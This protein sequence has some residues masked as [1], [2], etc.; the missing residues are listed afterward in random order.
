M[1]KTLLVITIALAALGFGCGH[2]RG[3]GDVAMT[4]HDE[5]HKT[6]KLS[7]GAHVEVAGINGSVKIETSDGDVAEVHILRDASDQQTLAKTAV[8]IVQSPNSLSVLGEQ[9]SGGGFLREIF[10]TKQHR[11]RLQVTLKIPKQVDLLAKGVN[12]P[13][14][15]GE[16]N[17]PVVVKS[18]NGPVE[19][20]QAASNS[21]VKGVNGPVSIRIAQLGE[22]GPSVSGVN[23][24]IQILLADNLNADVDVKGI[25]GRVHSEMQNVTIEE[26]KNNRHYH[27]R[28]GNGGTE[29]SV[30][31]INGNVTLVS[32]AIKDKEKDAKQKDSKQKDDKPSE[33]EADVKS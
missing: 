33:E 23:G 9:Q 11:S 20:A 3:G 15:V 26:E 30:S 28:V 31:G 4:A 2:G 22:Q 18:V 1:N 12:G 16:I 24:N 25:N 8:D 29:I 10:D 17:G 5:I 21:E 19:I 32:A 27:A 6:F 14:T 7:P 13:V